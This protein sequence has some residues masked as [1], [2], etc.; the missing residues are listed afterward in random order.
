[1]HTYKTVEEIVEAY[2]S[3]KLEREYPIFYKAIEEILD[4]FCGTHDSE[5]DE[6]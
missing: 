6:Y 5:Y 1:M 4:D 2:Y 3:G